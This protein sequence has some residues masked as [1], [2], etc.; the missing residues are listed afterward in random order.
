MPSREGEPGRDMV[1]VLDDLV[2]LEAHV[3]QRPEEALVETAYLAF[4]HRLFGITVER[5]GLIVEFEIAVEIARVPAFDRTEECVT[6]R[7]HAPCSHRRFG[8]INTR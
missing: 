3:G 1:R 7:G 5:D 4:G 6:V 2:D 8:R